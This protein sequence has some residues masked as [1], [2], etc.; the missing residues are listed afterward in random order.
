MLNSDIF[1]FLVDL[2]ENNTREWMEANRSR[3][4]A[5]RVDLLHLIQEI[6]DEMGV[7][8]P[9]VRMSKPSKSILRINR[10]LRFSK[11]KTPYKHFIGAIFSKD[12]AHRSYL[13]DYYLHIQPGNCF[14]AGGSWYPTGEPM[15]KIRAK[16]DLEGERLEAIIQEEDF[17]RYFGG[18]E[19]EKL[20]SSPRDYPKDHPYIHLLNHKTFT[21]SHQ[22]THEVL[23]QEDAPQVI[24]EGFRV[25]KP[26]YDFLVEALSIEEKKQEG[27]SSGIQLI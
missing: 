7:F 22:L 10:N 12:D 13:P 24:A 25:F 23:M 3:Y 15:A 26:F 27:F 17:Q 6:L 4:E 16:I 9:H 8:E 20:K 2:K 11:D 14:L 21:T 5:A 18:I 19:G 1:E